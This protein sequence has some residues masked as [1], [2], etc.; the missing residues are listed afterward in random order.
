M[1]GPTM[2]LDMAT[3]EAIYFHRYVLNIYGPMCA[4]VPYEEQVIR[5][6]ALV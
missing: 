3:Q 4:F 5:V 1:V 2:L 6:H